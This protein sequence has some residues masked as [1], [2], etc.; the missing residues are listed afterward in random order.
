MVT[1]HN[2]LER[3]LWLED[4]SVGQMRQFDGDSDGRI[5][6]WFLIKLDTFFLYSYWSK[7]FWTNRNVFFPPIK[8]QKQISLCK[9]SR[10]LFLL[11]TKRTNLLQKNQLQLQRHLSFSDHSPQLPN[12]CLKQLWSQLDK[13]CHHVILFCNQSCNL[14]WENPWTNPYLLSYLVAGFWGFLDFSG[15]S[16]L[17]RPNP[18]TG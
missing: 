14:W 2:N 18:P 1:N 9:K 17:L 6:T 11:Q 10:H 7:L 3:P 13:A 8:K 12:Q 16:E 4:P 15:I 5:V